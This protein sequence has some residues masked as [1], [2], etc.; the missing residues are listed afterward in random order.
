VNRSKPSSEA[1][2]KYREENSIVVEYDAER[3]R[4]QGVRRVIES[5]V[6]SQHSLIRHDPMKVAWE[7][8]K[9]IQEHELEINSKTISTPPDIRR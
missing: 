9:T 6:M 2:E 8:F 1:I 3:I 7:I 5:N 4:A